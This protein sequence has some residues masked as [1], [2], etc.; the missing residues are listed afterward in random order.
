MKHLLTLIFVLLL[1]NTSLVFAQADSLEIA[2]GFVDNEDF[3]QAIELYKRILVNDSLNPNINFKLGFCCLN[4]TYKK[5][6]AITYLQKAQR[7]YRKQNKVNKDY[8]ET[9]F[10]LARAYRVTYEPDS[11]SQVLL[12][13]KKLS[14]NKQV[15]KDIEKELASC[16]AVKK[17]TQNPI[18]ITVRNLGENVNSKYSDHSPVISADESVLIFTSRREG[19]TGGKLAQDGQYFEE[20]YISE[21]QYGSFDIPKS[22]GTNINTA[23]HEATIGLSVDGQELFIYKD[24]DEGSIYYSKLVGET[25][26]V[27]IKLGL[28]INTKYR[29]THASLSADG[30][31]LFF[32]SNRPGS[33][34]GMDIYFSKKLPNGEWGEAKNAG[35][36]V[37]TEYDEEGPYIHPDGKT[38]YFSSKGHEGLGG[39]DI[40]KSLMTEFK[41]WNKAENV[42]Y[43]INTTENDV[44]YVL[45]ADGKRAYFSSEREEGN[46]KT[47][48]YMISIEEAQNTNVTVMTGKGVVCSGAL[49]E[50]SVTITDN[51]TGEVVSITRINSK[52]GKFLFVV[53]KGKSYNILVDVAGKPVFAEDITIPEKAPSQ[54]LYKTIKLDPKV[55]CGNITAEGNDKN[56]AIDPN[57]IDED[58]NLYDANNKIQNILFAY[59]QAGNVPPNQSLDDL[60]EY[61]KKNPTAIIEIGAYADAKGTAKSNMELTEKRGQSVLKYMQKLK[62]NPAQLVIVAYGESNPFAIN[63]NPDGTWN[64]EGQK[65][66]RRIEFRVIKQG[67]ATILIRPIVDMP[68]ELKNKNYKRKYKKAETIE[69]ADDLN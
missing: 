59:G 34:G 33:L 18:A 42:G 27:P 66:N 69:E 41:T 25:W 50:A 64:K 16:E 19:G 4:T 11:A 49:P 54:Q 39:Y 44:F 17:F 10:Y 3:Q 32:T 21:K 14:S 5:K 46:G 23:G 48:I 30:Q 62:V 63:K 8:I 22:I 57:N 12:D 13:L 53:A 26:S 20:I 47:D 2:D 37:N 68:K 43:P 28:T 31:Y 51:G 9:S 35:P 15:I 1:A 6:D 36:G 24:E 38:L 40:F 52:T 56:D 60:A 58:G 29:E 55:D 7:L 45:S 61:L 67:E 65:F